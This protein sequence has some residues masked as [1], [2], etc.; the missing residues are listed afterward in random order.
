M[1]AADPLQVQVIRPGQT[2]VDMQCGRGLAPRLPQP[3]TPA[4]GQASLWRHRPRPSVATKSVPRSTNT[5]EI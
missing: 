5:S 4:S 2:Y 3:P 1:S